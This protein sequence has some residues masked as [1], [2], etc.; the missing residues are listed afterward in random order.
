MLN[1][2][3]NLK[4]SH[5]IL[6][7]IVL[8]QSILAIP[9]LALDNIIKRELEMN[10]MLEEGNEF[11]SDEELKSEPESETSDN[12]LSDS[13]N[14]DESITDET[15]IRTEENE[16]T[17]DEDNWDEYFENETDEIKLRDYG[18]RNVFETS[19]ISDDNKSL[20]DALSIQLHLSDLSEKQ[21]F[22]G[23][24]IIWSL[25]ESG[26]FADNS[27]DILL[28]IN[29]K[30]T[31]TK[32]ENDN[33][34]LKELYE[35]LNYIQKN[36]DPPGIAARNLKECIIIQIERSD[37]DN[38]IKELSKELL[39]KYFE[40][41][42]S[43]KYEKISLELNIELSKVKEVFE[44]IQKLNPKPG[45]S[46]KSNPENYIVPDLIV[47]KINDNY[48]IFLNERYTP[49]IRINKAYKNLY[50]NEKK[51]LD[52]STKDYLLSNFNRAKWFIEAINSR[53]DTMLKI[54]EAIINKQIG[55]FENHGEGLKQIYEKDIAEEIRM[56]RST[57]SRAVRGKYVQTDFGIYELRTFF[58]TPLS[59]TEGED[60]SSS[61]VK[62]RLKELINKENKRNPL[63]DQELTSKMNKM[64]FKMARRTVAKYRELIN[65]P[66][67]KL[68]R[69]I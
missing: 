63:T 35:T 42:L 29:A 41:L 47:K 53:R 40:D 19:Y 3:Q 15:N 43:K 17:K 24:E 8:D 54:M 26:Y 60:V 23:E 68:R 34:T 10:P 58:T 50:A 55:F 61:E 44:F 65:I 69:E 46:E 25:N 11:E 49:S 20:G 32:F 30:K 64:G 62:I 4:L 27:D 37:A 6:Q 31:G 5:K 56:D 9:V 36:F 66:N 12:N 2:T 45:S 28:D 51:N 16:L 18:E 39:E 22:I 7:K 52:N 59:T 33:F 57:I 14:N 48:E 13:G 38:E 67:A 1:Q 21:I